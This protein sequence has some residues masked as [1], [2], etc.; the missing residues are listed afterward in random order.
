VPPCHRSWK[1]AQADRAR[2]GPRRAVPPRLPGQDRGQH[3][4]DHPAAC[5]VAPAPVRSALTWRQFLRAQAASVLAV[6]FLHR[7]HGAP[8]AAVGP[9]RDRGRDPPGPCAGGDVT[10][11]RGVG[12]TAGPQPGY[13]P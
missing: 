12:D 2:A 10:S 13:G 8:A 1:P 3:G 7:G 9:V 4:V 6:D 5:R 11:S